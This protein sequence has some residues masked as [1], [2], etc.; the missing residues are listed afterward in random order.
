MESIRD[1][2]L[3]LAVGTVFWFAGPGSWVGLVW[4]GSA[5]GL[6]S[7]SGLGSGFGLESGFIHCLQRPSSEQENCGKKIKSKKKKVKS[8]NLFIRCT[9]LMLSL[10]SPVVS[11][12]PP[13]HPV[14]RLQRASRGE[15]TPHNSVCTEDDSSPKHLR[16][17]VAC[18][19]LVNQPAYTYTYTV[20]SSSSV[21]AQS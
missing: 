15:K 1:L 4:L 8:K 9:E 18:A 3:G 20:I 19:H 10:P 2:G 16:T 21:Y 11:T 14:L 5:F 12:T 7:G 17:N 6:G 13:R